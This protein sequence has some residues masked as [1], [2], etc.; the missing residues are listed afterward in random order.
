MK[1]NHIWILGVFAT[2]VAHEGR[3]DLNGRDDFNDNSKDPARWGTDVTFGSGANTF[4]TETNGRLEV[5]TSG[6]TTS[7]EL[8]LRPWALNF[9]SYTQDWSIQVNVNLTHLS[10]SVRFGLFVF[11]GQVPSVGA[12]HRFDMNLE[13]EAGVGDHWFDCRVAVNSA[14]SELGHTMTT[15][16]LA[17]L[18]VAFDANTKTLSGYYDDDGPANGYSFT[19]LGST[20]VPAG[21]NM[22][23]NS[24][25]GVAV[26][27]LTMSASVASTNNV[28]GD[29]FSA[30]SGAIPRLGISLVDGK[31]VTAWSTNAAAYHLEFTSALTPPVNWMDTTNAPVIVGTNF[32]ATR[33]PSGSNR[34]NR[35]SR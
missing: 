3:A 9:G 6:V 11:P 8:R 20:N 27:G 19:L 15:S 18:H 5:T 12:S 33:P 26:Y 23:S 28:F 25:F 7:F 22:T 29:N 31:V 17:T 30:A 1:T 16:T 14:E 2:F 10:Q 13:N 35:L 4:L 21:W 34:F 32:T 24:V